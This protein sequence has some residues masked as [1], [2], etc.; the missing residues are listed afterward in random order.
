MGFD[1]KRD[2]TLP[3]F[4]GAS[5]LFLDVG[6]LLTVGAL[7]KK[8]SLF[9]FFFVCLFFCLFV[10]FVCFCFFVK[11]LNPKPPQ[12]FLKIHSFDHHFYSFIGQKKKKKKVT[13]YSMPF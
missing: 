5:P 2:F 8:E 6:Y 12:A 11:C 3:T 9:C 13:L 1:S 10:L 7:C 4:A